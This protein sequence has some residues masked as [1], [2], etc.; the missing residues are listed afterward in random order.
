[1][2]QA[3]RAR[4]GGGEQVNGEQVNGEQVNGGQVLL[5]DPDKMLEESES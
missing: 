1:M 3:R 5:K 4:D 2:S